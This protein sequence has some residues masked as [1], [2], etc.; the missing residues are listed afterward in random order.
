LQSSARKRKR[1]VKKRMPTSKRKK[2]KKEVYVLNQ[3]VTGNGMI[4]VAQQPIGQSPVLRS[5]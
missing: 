3:P 4:N 2:Q 5:N 1:H